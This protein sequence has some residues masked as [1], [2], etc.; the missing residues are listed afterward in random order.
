MV[1]IEISK[2]IKELWSQTTLGLIQGKINVE[3]SCED[4]LSDIDDYCNTLQNELKV[5]ELSSEKP[6]K[7]GREAYKSLGKSP[8][9]YRLSSEA[10]VRRIL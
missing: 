4:L 8:S 5:E 10:L 1:H 7:D 9:K 6:I 3:D 2:E